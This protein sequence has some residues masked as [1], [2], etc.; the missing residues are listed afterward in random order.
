MIMVRRLFEI[1]MLM[2]WRTISKRMENTRQGVG[3]RDDLLKAH[4]KL[5]AGNEF[6]LS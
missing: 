1:D 3:G 2:C 4:E 5:R 6:L